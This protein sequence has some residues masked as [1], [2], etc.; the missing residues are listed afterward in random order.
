MRTRHIQAQLVG[1]LGANHLLSHHTT[2]GIEQLD[3]QLQAAHTLRI[4]DGNINIDLGR[5]I[6]EL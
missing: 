4:V 6:G 3:V 1:S 5:S 2:I